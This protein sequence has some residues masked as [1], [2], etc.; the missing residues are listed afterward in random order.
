MIRIVTDGPI[1]TEFENWRTKAEAARHAMI[2]EYSAGRI[3]DPNRYQDIW[4]ELKEIFLLNVFHRKCAFCEAKFQ[5][6]NSIPHVDHYRPKKGVTAERKAIGHHGYFWLACEWYNLLLV[7]HC[8]N[9]GHSEVVNGTRDSHPGKANEFQ[10]EGERIQS[11]SVDSTMWAK[12][13]ELERPLL[14]N[15]YLDDPE[16]HIAFSNIGVPYPKSRSKRGA[17][18]IEACH[19]DRESLSTARLEVA[20]DL[21]RR[22]FYSLMERPTSL[23]EPTDP[24][25]A[26]L[27]HAIPMLLQKKLEEGGLKVGEIS[28]K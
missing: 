4:K 28:V 15:P 8:C 14:L 11:P 12:D 7:C 18:T 21:A 5:L 23:W 26:W 17:A 2:Q 24:F 16:E 9:S 22:R 10:I 25:S 20:N 27:K 13:L 1:G 19:L 6:A 3:P